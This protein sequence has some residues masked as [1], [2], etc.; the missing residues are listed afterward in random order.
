MKGIRAL[1]SLLLLA[2]LAAC[3][4]VTSTLPPEEPIFFS[5]RYDA[6]FDATLQEM[7]STYLRSSGTRI[8]FAVTE[9]NRDTGLVTAV[10]NERGPRS[11]ISLRGGRYYD[12]DDD[13]DE[14]VFFGPFFRVYVPVP[15][16]DSERTLISVVLRPAERGA[17]LVYSS[18]GSSGVTSRTANRFMAQVVENLRERFPSPQVEP[19]NNSVAP[20]NP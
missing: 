2:L 10:R 4:P 18:S 5:A 16:G 17:T 14:G 20:A 13:R 3:A 9:A 8:T 19:A 11:S 7:T 6:L 15:V 1:P 12:R